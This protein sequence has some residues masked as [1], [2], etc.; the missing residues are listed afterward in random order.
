MEQ[1]REKMAQLRQ[2]LPEEFLNLEGLK[3]SELSETM[4]EGEQKLDDLEKMLE[5]NRIDDA[6][7]ALDELSE[8]LDAFDKLVNKDMETL[9]RE[10]DPKRQQAIS[11][12][13]DKTRDLMKKQQ[14]L[15]DQTRDT[16]QKGA[17]A[18][19][20]VMK[21]DDGR[22]LDEIAA[23]LVQTERKINTLEAKK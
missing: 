4:A 11:E 18:F 20:R 15:L 22:P 5:E 12:L 10:G 23:E 9:N 19:D 16:A 2:K 17:Q 3:G 14:E 21:E 13:M 8:S 6:M 1:L 7:K